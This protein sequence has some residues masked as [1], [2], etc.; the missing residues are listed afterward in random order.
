MYVCFSKRRDQGTTWHLRCSSEGLGFEAV[1][2]KPEEAMELFELWM[3][4][5]RTAEVLFILTGCRETVRLCYTIASLL[6]N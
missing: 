5:G 6:K 2:P 3:D 1:L 4:L